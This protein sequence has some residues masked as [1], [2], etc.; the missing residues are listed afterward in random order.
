M[1]DIEQRLS[2]MIKSSREQDGFN[3]SEYERLCRDALT[4]LE[5]RNVLGYWIAGFVAGLV[6][7]IAIMWIAS[8]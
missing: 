7:G 8:N 5:R 6:A 3:W 4:E 2:S 1:K